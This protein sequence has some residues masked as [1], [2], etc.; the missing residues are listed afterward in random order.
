MF[1]KFSTCGIFK[2]HLTFLDL[3]GNE[4]MFFIEASI[5]EEKPTVLQG[6][7]STQKETTERTNLSVAVYLLHLIFH[8]FKKYY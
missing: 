3:Q 4:I 5:I 8:V 1:K 6:S 7:K 2:H